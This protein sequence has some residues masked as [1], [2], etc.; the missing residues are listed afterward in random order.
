MKLTGLFH[1][2]L[3]N[4]LEMDWIWLRNLTERKV[5]QTELNPVPVSKTLTICFNMFQVALAHM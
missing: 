3:R 5:V 2:N 4:I 1:A